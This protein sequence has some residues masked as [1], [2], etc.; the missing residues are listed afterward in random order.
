MKDPFLG[1][2][3]KV[4]C[5][6]PLKNNSINIKNHLI[7]IKEKGLGPADPRQPNNEFWDDKAEKWGVT[8]GDA[9]GRLCANCRFFVNSTDIKNC[10]ENGPAKDLKASALPL[11]PKW[12]DI[13]SK[14]VAFCVLLDITCSPIR[15]CDFQQLGGPIDDDKRSLPEYSDILNEELNEEG[16][17][18]EDEE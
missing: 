1:K 15:T 4:F 11:N 14:P 2:V 17:D 10:I 12:A 6:E 9:R 8:Q 5:P 18:G 7:G 3:A 16:E 13:E